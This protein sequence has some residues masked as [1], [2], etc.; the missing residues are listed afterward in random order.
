MEE[1]TK[2]ETA[3]TTKSHLFKSGEERLAIWREIRG[4]WKGC[5]PDPIAWLE[6][7]REGAER[8]LPPLHT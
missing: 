1:I 8:E 7:S 2:Q 5:D 4:M 3:G 6:Q